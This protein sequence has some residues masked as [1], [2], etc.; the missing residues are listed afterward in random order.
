MRKVIIILLIA[1][2]LMPLIHAIDCDKDL[3]IT[4]ITKDNNYGGPSIHGDYIVYYETN[5]TTGYFGKIYVYDL[6]QKTETLLDD[7]EEQFSGLKVYSNFVIYG[8]VV[9]KSS[10]FQGVYLY[11]LNTKQKTVLN[12]NKRWIYGRD[13]S[14]NYAIWAL[15]DDEEAAI[16]LYDIKNKKDEEIY[17]VKG[18]VSSPVIY[19]KYAVWVH[20]GT[21]SD[22]NPE[23]V[24]N[25]LILYNIDTK[26][27]T[28]IS[29]ILSG[30]TFLQIK[31]VGNKI[32][33]TDGEGWNRD[34]Y[35]YDLV[36]KEKN[37]LTDNGTMQYDLVADENYII[38]SQWANKK[39]NTYLFNLSTSTQT[40]IS[41]DTFNIDS[42]VIYGDKMVFSSF[43]GHQAQIF[44][45]NGVSCLVN[46]EIPD[47]PIINENKTQTINVTIT[48]NNSIN[49]S[50]QII[51][52]NTSINETIQ[53]E[54]IEN[55][56]SNVTFQPNATINITTIIPET[57]KTG[58]FNSIKCFIIKIF[59]KTC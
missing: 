52:E 10:S 18:I 8:K 27:F 51:I 2:I 26:E 36:A 24:V 45:L 19:G 42:P 16:H 59:S 44:L 48:I 41:K 20:Y 30:D 9:Q 5:N 40:K 4:Q 28:K 12:D 58:F 39:I 31:F 54:S 53:K 23:Q 15:K 13:V 34:I 50:E 37:K 32:I 14:N 49:N 7:S 38:L 29:D 56:S 35:E 46:H 25:G 21:Y 11:N 43:V 22:G 17:L 47:L 33:W 55:E 1:I 57:K 6:N 3:T